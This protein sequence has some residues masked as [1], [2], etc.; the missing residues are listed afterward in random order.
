MAGSRPGNLFKFG[1][2]EGGFAGH[3]VMIVMAVVVVVKAVVVQ[4]AVAVAVAVRK[5]RRLP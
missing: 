2:R 5:K 1:R 4:V 3:S